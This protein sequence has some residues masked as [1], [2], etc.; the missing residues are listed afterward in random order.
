MTAYLDD[1]QQRELVRHAI[2]TAD[3]SLEC[4]DFGPLDQ[5]ERRD[6]AMCVFQEPDERKW[7]EMYL[8]TL[9]SE[10]AERYMD[11]NM[12][13]C[14]QEDSAQTPGAVNGIG[15]VVARGGPAR[16]GPG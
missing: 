12:H 16:G 5:R 3:F 1:A 4:L 7:H 13:E 2:V 10:A 15:F 14:R 11:W 6:E 9:P 8:D